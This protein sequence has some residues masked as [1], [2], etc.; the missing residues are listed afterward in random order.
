MHTF[1]FRCPTTGLNVQGHGK[2]QDLPTQT[3]VAQH[4]PVCGGVHLVNP[5]TGKLMSEETAK[6]Q[7]KTQQR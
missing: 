5:R 4:C 7:G 6:P 2:A 1:L 3:Y